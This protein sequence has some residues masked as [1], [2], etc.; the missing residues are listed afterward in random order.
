[1]INKR[2]VALA[3]IPVY[4]TFLDSLWIENLCLLDF[5]LRAWWLDLWI[6]PERV[7]K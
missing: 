3:P 7:L 4:D 2:K 5:L 6:L 1:M